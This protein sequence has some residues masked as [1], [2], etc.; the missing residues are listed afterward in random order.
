MFYQ[1]HLAAGQAVTPRD[2]PADAA[3][4]R[5]LVRELLAARR[6][7]REASRIAAADAPRCA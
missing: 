4:F 7:R 2:A 5:A 1:A 3:T 6:Q